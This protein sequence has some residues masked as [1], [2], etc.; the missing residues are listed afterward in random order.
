MM[1]DQAQFR[2]LDRLRGLALRELIARRPF[3]RGGMDWEQHTVA[4]W[5]YLQMAMGKPAMDWTRT[6]PRVTV[7]AAQ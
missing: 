6:P 5:T 4:A 7:G 2:T 3:K 1:H